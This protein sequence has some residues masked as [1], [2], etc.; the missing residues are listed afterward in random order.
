MATSHSIE[1]LENAETL[2]FPI[3]TN[4]L[5]AGSLEA[6][7]S[8]SF[9]MHSHYSIDS[10]FQH[11]QCTTERMKVYLEV[12]I[13]VL[14]NTRRNKHGSSLHDFTIQ[15]KS[16]QSRLLVLELHIAVAPESP[17]VAENWT[18]LSNLPTALKELF[19]F[20]FRICHVVGKVADKDGDVVFAAVMQNFGDVFS[21]GGWLFLLVCGVIW[22][23]RSTSSKQPS[24]QLH[25]FFK[26][27][28]ITISL[29]S[30]AGLLCR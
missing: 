9:P 20:Y 29:M 16:L 8:A 7:R 10:L 18:D 23:L 24:F 1:E 28:T 15:P 11:I 12:W 6:E 2:P 25:V 5:D 17:L 3:N 26:K 21:A 27:Q 19:Q 14:V 22:F 13:L 30:L 4:S